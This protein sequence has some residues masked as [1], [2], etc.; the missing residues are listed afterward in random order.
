MRCLRRTRWW[1]RTRPSCARP[2]RST[3]RSWAGHGTGTAPRV[4]LAGALGSEGLEGLREMLVARKADKFEWLLDD[5]IEEEKA[6]VVHG[7]RRPVG[8]GRNLDLRDE[9]RRIE[10]LVRR[11]N[12]DDLRLEAR[13]NWRQA[14]S[15]TEWVYNENIYKHRKSRFVYTKLLSILG[16]AW[17][18]TEALRVFTIMRGD[19]QIYPD[20]AAYHSIAVTLGRAGL[21][22]EL[23]KI[24]EYMKQKPLKRVMKMRR[25]DWDP[26][27][28]PDVLIYNSVLNACV[29]SH[30]WKGVFW[31][32]QQMRF[33]GLTP[34][35]AT[36]GLAMEMEKNGVTPRA[37]TYKVL[38]R[39]FWEQG[40]VNEAVEAVKE[41]EQR[42]VVGAASVYYE[43]AC[44]LCNNGRW[45]DALLQVEKIKRLPLTKPLEFTFTGMILASFDG[46]YISE[47]ISIFESMKGHC[48]PNIGTI[49]VM[50]K[51]YG[52]CDMFGKARDLFETTKTNFT[53]SN[54][55]LHKADT[56]TYNS[57]LEA[58]ASAQQW[59]YFENVYREM[60]LS[61][62]HLDQSKYSWML[63]KA[64]KAGK[65]FLLEHA[66]DSI[67]ERGEIPN[68]QL[69]TEMICQTIAQSDYARTL[70]LLNVMT[71]ASTSVNELQWSKLLEQN[72]YRFSV[73]ALN[74]ILMYLSGSDTIKSDP[75]LSF[76]RA[77]QSQRGKT[78]V[79]DASFMADDTNMERSQLF[80]PE[81]IAKSSNSNLMGQDWLTCKNSVM[82]NI[83]PD[84][85]CN[86]EFSDH[87]MDT[88]Q[89]GA[90]ADLNG[91][92]VI[93]GLHSKSKHKEQCDL[94]P[95]GTGVSAIDEVLNS[96]NLY[97]D[98]SYGEMPSASEILELWQQE[99]ID[100]MI[101]V[102][103][104][105]AGSKADGWSKADDGVPRKRTRPY[106]LRR[107]S[108]RLR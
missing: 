46:G 47:C 20:M 17:R 9:E 86:S 38:V 2:P 41:M 57:M 59:E 33:G 72:I 102:K 79:K 21:I 89:F 43:L 97:G 48:A 58:A 28:E 10:S 70:H 66:L 68:V 16:K 14:L 77:L 32:F 64:S 91:D 4:P 87:I 84:D 15:V 22:N 95:L 73:N 37:I 63:V 62:H 98:A 74:D 82:T 108:V 25:K 69:F 96:M 76:V 29:L 11:L 75:A 34:T 65:S 30:Q 26:T 18:P 24:I 100:G 36:F 6:T 52:R 85:K 1:R 53:T 88:P 56:Y 103:K 55:S 31:V 44:C 13:G 80:L 27:L 8:T 93:C 78:F 39:A 42:G 23:I 90:N 92:I 105:R 83:F 81:N 7:R 101:S 40:K 5:D 61:H 54:H 60:A 71:E 107:L 12:E 106:H 104:S 49:N 51:V 67:L 45:K 35:G 99:R 50:I 19:A 94:G 3:A